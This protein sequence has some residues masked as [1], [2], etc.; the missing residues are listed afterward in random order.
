MNFFL[1]EHPLTLP[2][3]PVSHLPK[4]GPCLQ[5]TKS[6]HQ[7]WT[8]CNSNNTAQSRYNIRFYYKLKMPSII[9]ITKWLGGRG[10]RGDSAFFRGSLSPAPDLYPHRRVTKPSRWGLV[11]SNVE[12]VTALLFFCAPYL[13]SELCSFFPQH[14]LLYYIYTLFFKCSKIK[15]FGPSLFAVSS[16]GHALPQV[17][18]LVFSWED[19][20]CT[21]TVNSF[22]GFTHHSTSVN[23]WVFS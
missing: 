7:R 9:L 4:A 2:P 13:F 8:Q 18:F 20:Y 22:A 14:G 1:S 15:R 6:Q 10:L 5:S 19:V 3:L 11:F 17:H 16:S 21:F 23:H 12:M